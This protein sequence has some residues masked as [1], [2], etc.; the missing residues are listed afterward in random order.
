MEFEEWK[1]R[2]IQRLMDC[3]DYSEELAAE[4]FEN[5]WKS[6]L[7]DDWEDFRPEDVAD[8]TLSDIDPEEGSF[9]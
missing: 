1:H 6:G 7:F 2:Y 4:A 8:D 9:W 3:A 5:G